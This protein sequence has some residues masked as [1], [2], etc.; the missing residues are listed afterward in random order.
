MF[1]IIETNC[2]I[3]QLNL[4]ASLNQVTNLVEKMKIG[5]IYEKHFSKSSIEKKIKQCYFSKKLRIILK[6]KK[7]VET[8]RKIKVLNLK[9]FFLI[10]IA[11]DETVWL[12]GTCEHVHSSVPKMFFIS[13][14]SCSTRATQQ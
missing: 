4:N 10:L 5:K 3:I 13:K 6:Q 1:E 14:K 11:F 8:C 12:I 2:L 9:F 7:I